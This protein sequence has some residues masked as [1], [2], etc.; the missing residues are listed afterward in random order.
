MI[1]QVIS[2]THDDWKALRDEI[3]RRKAN[4]RYK[5]LKKLLE[6]A[7]FVLCRSEGSHR[8]FCKPGCM[9]QPSIKEE[10]GQV[11]IGHVVTVLNAVEECGDE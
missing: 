10:P 1:S 3:K 9:P 4:V 2:V 8:M 5:E 11:K 7:G 6:A